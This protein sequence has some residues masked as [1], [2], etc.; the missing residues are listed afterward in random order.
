MPKN[1]SNKPDPV[2]PAVPRWLTIEDQRRRVTDLGRWT[3]GR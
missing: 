1:E 2:N 3:E